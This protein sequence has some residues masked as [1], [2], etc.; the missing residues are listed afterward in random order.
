MY[1]SHTVSPEYIICFVGTP[2]FPENP[3]KWSC[4]CIPPCLRTWVCRQKAGAGLCLFRLLLLEKT[5]AKPLSPHA[6]TSPI[7]LFF[8]GDIY[9]NNNNKNHRAQRSYLWPWLFIVVKFYSWYLALPLFLYCRIEQTRSFILLKNL[10]K[11]YPMHLKTAE[12]NDLAIFLSW[13]QNSIIFSLSEKIWKLTSLQLTFR[14]P[15]FLRWMFAFARC[16][17]E[18]TSEGNTSSVLKMHRMWGGSKY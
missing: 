14:G 10:A 8:G 1:N 2:S 13:Y 9:S 16:G 12:G 15:I 4:H 17:P 3:W 18:D 11:Y 7:P 5:L 6:L